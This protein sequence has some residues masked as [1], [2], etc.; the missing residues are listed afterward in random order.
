MP[1]KDPEARRAYINARYARL[2]AENSELYQKNKEYHA[3][4]HK[5]KQET[6]PEYVARRKE[7]YAKWYAENGKENARVRKGYKSREQHDA[8]QEGKREEWTKERRKWEQTE[9]GRRYAVGAQVKKRCGM[10]IDEYDEAYVGQE[11]KCLICGTFRGQY[12]K[13]RLVVDHC[14]D[15]GKFRALLCAN[16][17]SGLGFFG[18]NPETLSNA[19]EY[20]KRFKS[21]DSDYGPEGNQPAK[22]SAGSHHPASR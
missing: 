5:E 16:C 22:H 2:K 7:N 10:T 13:D 21:G 8:E 11:G 3:S 12:A 4:L 19:V 20:L 15:S 17:N 1:H 18:D 6:D 9:D 14:H